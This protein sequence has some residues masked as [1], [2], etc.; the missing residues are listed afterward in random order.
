MLLRNG[1]LAPVSLVFLAGAIVMMLFVILS[2]VKPT[3][4][5]DATYFLRADTSDITGARATSQWAYFY[6]C[7]PGN[8]ECGGAWP[9]PPV[10]W[11]WEADA[12]GVPPG[13]AGGHGGNT[14]S[15][16][17]YYLWRFGWVFYLMGFA[18]AV[19]AFFGGFLAC[20]GRLGAALAGLA[21]G[22]ALFFFSLAAALMTATFVKMRDAFRADGR[23]A[24]LGHYA[25]G[26]TWAAWTC[27]LISTTL[28]FLGVLAGAGGRR[29]RKTAAASS[30]HTA[31]GSRRRRGRF[32]G[33]REP[34]IRNSVGSH[35]VK[36][37][38][39]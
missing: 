26:F 11:A 16:Y 5:L 19:G 24:T 35:R 12:A 36:E 23:D 32:G 3:S 9:D 15:A 21:A 7:S 38:Y 31:G 30:V 10:G 2:G 27:L 22:S 4:P 28:F 14:T 29:D 37:D 6:I 34:S 33:R 8:T 18:L 39:A 20:L 13:L 1:I 25:F 17:Y